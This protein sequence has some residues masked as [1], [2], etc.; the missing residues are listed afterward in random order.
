MLRPY[1]ELGIVLGSIYLIQVF[2]QIEVMTG[3]GPGLDERAL[4]RLPALDRRW[5]GLRPGVRLQHHRGHRLDHHRDVR[6]A[7]PVQ[8]VRAP[9][10]GMNL[11]ASRPVA[12]RETLGHCRARQLT[13]LVAALFFFP[14]FWMVLN[15]FKTELVANTQAGALLRAHAGA[16]AGRDRGATAGCSASAR[17]SRN[18]FVIVDHLD[19]RSCC[20][21]RSRLPTPWRSTVIKPGA[22]CCSSSSPRSSCPS[23]RPSCRSGS[24]PGT[25]AAEHAPGAHHP[26][27]GHEPAAGHLDAALV[28]RRGAARAHRGRPDGRRG[29][30][31][32]DQGR[33][34]ADRRARASRRRRCCA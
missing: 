11:T 1:L 19:A 28:L 30:A 14:V 22:T 27:H 12:R 4:L 16:L 7:R 15:S 2:D 10:A 24:S 13:W 25:W 9:G 32:P 6:A 31:R 26:V 34:A 17:R 3:G 8:P 33:D 23:W 21:W 5:L 20:C 29:A 18:S